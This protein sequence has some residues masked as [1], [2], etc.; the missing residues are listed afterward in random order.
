M[1]KVDDERAGDHNSALVTYNEVV[2]DPMPRAVADLMLRADATIEVQYSAM[3][4]NGA[5]TF[6]DWDT[7]S[8][9]LD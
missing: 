6:N 5:F 4:A 1:S 7:F 3:R 9:K 8:T 2:A